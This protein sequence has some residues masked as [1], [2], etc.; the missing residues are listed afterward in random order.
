MPQRGERQEA[1]KQEVEK[2][3]KE[4]FIEEIQFPKWLADPVMVKK[5]NGD[6]RMCVDFTNLNNTCFKDCYPLTRINTLINVIVGHEMLSFMDDF[7]GYT[8]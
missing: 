2:L 7:N 1:I 8:K 3:L 5:A 6:S 4:V